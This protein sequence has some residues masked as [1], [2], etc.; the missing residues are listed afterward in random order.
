MRFI[1]EIPDS[2]IKNYDDADQ[3]ANDIAQAIIDGSVFIETATVR[4]E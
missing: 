2:E 1:V 3:A 4:K